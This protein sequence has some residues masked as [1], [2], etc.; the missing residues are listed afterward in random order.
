MISFDPRD[1]AIRIQGV[2]IKAEAVPD[3]LA[4]DFG[5]AQIRSAVRDDVGQR[6][7]ER[8]PYAHERRSEIFG[9]RTMRRRRLR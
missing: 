2:M 6:S 5:D 3:N 8:G 1:S 4:I 7:L 9:G